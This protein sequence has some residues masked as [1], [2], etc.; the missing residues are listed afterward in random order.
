MTAQGPISNVSVAWYEYIKRVRPLF[1]R[2]NAYAFLILGGLYWRLA[3]HFGGNM[4][5]QQ[6]M[7]GPLSFATH[8]GLGHC[9]IGDDVS[10]EER[11]ILLGRQDSSLVRS[12]WPAHAKLHISGLLRGGW[13]DMDVMWF[14]DRLTAV[15]EGRAQ[16]RP[17]AGAE[18]DME[19]STYRSQSRA[20]IANIHRE[21]SGDLGSVELDEGLEL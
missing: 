6:P 14:Q 13:T 1:E 4:L 12:W 3:L 20:K 5:A 18:W 2:A 7:A 11:G 19:L 16:G 21:F 9:N 15:I 8:G 17:L 10:P